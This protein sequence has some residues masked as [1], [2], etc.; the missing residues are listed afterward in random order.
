MSAKISVIMPVYNTQDYLKRAVDSVLNQT[1]EEWELI[2]INDGSTD[3]SLSVCK[4]YSDKYPDKIYVYS[5][6]NEGQGLARNL[7]IDKCTGEY[8]MFLDSDDWIDPD[9][10]AF[11][12]NAI[13]EYNSDVVECGCRSVDKNGNILHDYIVRDT[14][15]MNASECIDHLL[16]S[17]D[18]VGPG[19]CCKLYKFETVRNKRFPHIRAYEDYQFIYDYCVDVNKYV[20][21]YEPKWNYFCRPNSTMTSAFNLRKIGLVD[22]QK[23]I[24]EILR[25]KGNRNQF[26]KAQKILSSKQFYILSS[27]LNNLQLN[28]AKEA[29]DKLKYDILSSYDEY[30]SNPL[31]GKNRIML[32]LIN[33]TPYS[34]WKEILNMRFS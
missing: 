3:D 15:I 25:K 17:D 19:A 18:A 11:L 23:G 31:M 21:I 12:L 16:S 27:L 30:M 10:L 29:A 14:I 33:Y 1:Y 2:L 9:T 28:G 4:T 7:A 24:C 6:E 20:H 32:W 8:A 26:L 34:L 13:K 22:A 5:K